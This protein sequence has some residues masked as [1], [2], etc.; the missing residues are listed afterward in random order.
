MGEE[1]SLVWRV[2]V[3]LVVLCCSMWLFACAHGSQA[4]VMEPEPGKAPEAVPA[5]IALGD[6]QLVWLDNRGQVVQTFDVDAPEGVPA[7]HA[8][9]GSLYLYA[10]HAIYHVDVRTGASRIVA[11]L[12]TPTECGDL[13]VDVHSPDYMSLL[14]NQGDTLCLMM[15]DAHTNMASVWIQYEVDL[16]SGEVD[17]ELIVDE[18]YCDLPTAGDQPQLCGQDR[19]G[20]QVAA[21]VEDVELDSEACTVKT[22]GGPVY[23]DCTECVADDRPECDLSLEAVT[24]SG[25]FALT[26]SYL[27][28]ADF[29]YRQI[30]IVDLVQGRVLETMTRQV[31]GETRVIVAPGDDLA[32]IDDEL[33][34]LGDA[35]SV[36]KVPPSTVFVTGQWPAQPGR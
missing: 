22:A 23:I 10:D 17:L 21:P 12:P 5:L 28:G 2:D 6:G 27:V 25:R 32:L 30:N 26:S 35:P 11:P 3:R 1:G 29:I 4:V 24:S 13:E 31:V 8:G 16:G 9:S 15:T 18:G 20:A 7:Y 19:Y 34:I 36:R 33:F 14:G